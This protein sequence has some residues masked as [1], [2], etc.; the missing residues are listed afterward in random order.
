MLLTVRKKIH[1]FKKIFFGAIMWPYSFSSPV[2]MSGCCNWWEGILFPTDNMGA[3]EA[4][5]R[6]HG[7][8][9]FSPIVELI[10]GGWSCEITWPLWSKVEIKNLKK[11][12]AFP[13]T[14]SKSLCESVERFLTWDPASNTSF[15]SLTELSHFLQLPAGVSACPAPSFQLVLGC[16]FGLLDRQLKERLK[17][18]EWLADYVASNCDKG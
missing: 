17:D 3:M 11:T 18:F 16:L 12:L 1:L 14:L 10:Q 7:S 4:G 2:S 6:C 8:V 13:S 9:Q 5:E 15:C